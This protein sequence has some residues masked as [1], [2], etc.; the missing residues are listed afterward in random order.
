MTFA[1]SIGVPGHSRTK[2]RILTLQL[3]SLH[4]TRS[5]GSR[6]EGGGGGG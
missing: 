5:Q 6:K 3:R 1:V 4:R 2:D